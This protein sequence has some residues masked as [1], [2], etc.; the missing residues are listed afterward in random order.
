MADW[1]AAPAATASPVLLLLDG[2]FTPGSFAR[3]FESFSILVLNLVYNQP[4]IIEGND[5]RTLPVQGNQS[6]CAEHINEMT[7]PVVA[8][9]V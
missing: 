2:D 3:P 6:D 7:L 4:F 5:L 8:L 9:N 1:P